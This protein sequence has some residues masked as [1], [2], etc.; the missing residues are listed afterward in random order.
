MATEPLSAEYAKSGK[1]GCKGCGKTID[2]GLL[3]VGLVGKA[4]FGATAWYHY[5]CI[6]KD[7]ENL[8]SVDSSK[9]TKE[10]VQNFDKLTEEDKKKLAK[11]LPK[12]CKEASKAEPKSKSDLAAEYAPSAKSS[13]KGCSKGIGKG[14]LR[15]GFPGK[16][17]FGA[18]AW[19]H[20][21]CVWKESA[22]LAPIDTSQ[23]LE[24]IVDGFKNLQKE[25]QTK[26]TS[27]LKKSCQAAAEKEPPLS[28]M[29]AEYAKSDKSECKGCSNKIAKNA[30]RVGFP[31]KANFGAI[32]WYH[33]ACLKESP[34]EYTKGINPGEQLAEVIDG[35]D[36]LDK[37]DQKKLEEEMKSLL[38][39]TGATKRKSEGKISV[40]V[41]RQ[42]F[43][44]IYSII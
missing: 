2:K 34:R 22:Y 30:M 35:F 33:P 11:D 6:W 44:I 39:P 23:S 13:C 9:P 15:M 41:I 21:D 27:D 17:N 8:K 32:A 12:F 37:A 29:T 40:I 26:L 36:K 14:T 5:D 43:S 1:A 28:K 7:A 10:L 31:K 4:N 24:E 16:A 25:D 38:S 42:I 20:Y 3:R 19:Y 18:P